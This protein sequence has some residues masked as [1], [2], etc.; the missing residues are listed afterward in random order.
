MWHGWRGL[1]E[2]CSKEVYGTSNSD[3]SGKALASYIMSLL[4]TR[5]PDGTFICPSLQNFGLRDATIALD[6]LRSF[7]SKRSCHPGGSEG[8]KAEICLIQMTRCMKSS[9]ENLPDIANANYSELCAALDESPYY[10]N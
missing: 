7:A 6:D 3:S 9:S 8:S 5:Q 10:A 2:R 4:Y 1:K